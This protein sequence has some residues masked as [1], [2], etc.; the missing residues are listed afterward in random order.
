LRPATPNWY[1]LAAK[2]ILGN[3]V[4]LGDGAYDDA[5]LHGIAGALF[6]DCYEF[7]EIGLTMI[8][9]KPML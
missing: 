2:L 3:K 4:F 5:T 8:L 7:L 9:E 1:T 6:D